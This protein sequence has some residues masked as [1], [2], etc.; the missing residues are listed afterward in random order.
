[1][2]AEKL[3]AAINEAATLSSEAQEALAAQIEAWLAD[4]RWDELLEDQRGDALVAELFREARN[5]PT[6]PCEWDGDEEAEGAG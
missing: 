3:Q 1:M 2:L 4:A 6:Y 5:S